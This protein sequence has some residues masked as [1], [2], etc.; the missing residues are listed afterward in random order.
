MHLCTN[1]WYTCVHICVQTCNCVHTCVYTYMYTCSLFVS[2]SFLNFV[3]RVC[4]VRAQ[5]CGTCVHILFVYKHVVHMC[6]NMQLYTNKHVYTCMYTWLH[7]VLLSFLNCV[8]RV[9]SV[10]GIATGII[11]L[12]RKMSIP[13]R[14][15]STTMRTHFRMATP[16][17]KTTIS[18]GNRSIHSNG[19]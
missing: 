10:K 9:C 1:M 13:P 5:T 15:S 14:Y 3:Y 11:A 7:F 6:T 4:S 2:F 16:P 12:Y 17:P 18:K 8:Y 19:M